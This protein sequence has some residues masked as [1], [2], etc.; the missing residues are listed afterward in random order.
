MVHK[1]FNGSNRLPLKK[2]LNGDVL[3]VLIEPQT[4]ASRFYKINMAGYFNNIDLDGISR[5]TN[6]S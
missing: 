3:S 6:K 5:S 1:A 4:Q 2:K